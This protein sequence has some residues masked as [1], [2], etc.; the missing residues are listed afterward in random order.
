MLTTTLNKDGICVVEAQLDFTR[1][2]K[3]FIWNYLKDKANCSLPG[4]K[5]KSFV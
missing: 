4:K 3:N 5:N 2:T 1:C